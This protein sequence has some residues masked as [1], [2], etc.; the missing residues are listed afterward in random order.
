MTD[1][2]DFLTESIKNKLKTF[3]SLSKNDQIK[4]RND[5]INKHSDILSKHIGYFNGKKLK[6]TFWWDLVF[7]TEEII[8]A[9]RNETICKFSFSE[10]GVSTPKQFDLIG[11]IIINKKFDQN[12]LFRVN[13]TKQRLRTANSLLQDIIEERVNEE[14]GLELFN[15]NF[16]LIDCCE[17]YKVLLRSF[18]TT[19]IPNTFINIILKINEI[20]DEN[21]KKICTKAMYYALPNNNRMILESNVMLCYRICVKTSTM[22]NAD[23]QMD[24]DGMSIVMMPNLFLMKDQDIEIERVLDLVEFCKYFYRIFPEIC[25]VDINE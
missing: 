23:K 9:H 10:E 7:T 8:I 18:N 25:K 17:L 11:K 24:L 22:T 5:F 19:I 4:E 20:E 14:K 21:N 12:G 13:S 16:D 6:S 3:N 1:E 2:I 15:K